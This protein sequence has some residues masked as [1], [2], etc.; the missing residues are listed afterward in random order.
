M[1]AWHF[2]GRAALN[3]AY[4]SY[5]EVTGRDSKWIQ[6]SVDQSKFHNNDIGKPELKFIHSSGREVVFDGDDYSV[7][8]GDRYRGT[9]NYVNPAPLPSSVLDVGGG[10]AYIGR[11]AGHILLD[12]VPYALGGNARG[13]N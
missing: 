10:A 7:I 12:V 4:P 1:T 2:E 9:Y 6:L 8:R 5:A 13:P 11:G 3:G